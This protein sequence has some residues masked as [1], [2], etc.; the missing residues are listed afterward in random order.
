MLLSLGHAELKQQFN[1]SALTTSDLHNN[2]HTAVCFDKHAG[3]FGILHLYAQ[4]MV[5]LDGASAINLTKSFLRAAKPFQL[6]GK[7]VI[8]SPLPSWM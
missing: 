8:R 4:G 2:C 7:E 5:C 3:R 1:N 6:V